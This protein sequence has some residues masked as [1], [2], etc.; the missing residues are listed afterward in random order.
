MSISLIFISKDIIELIDV[1]KTKPKRKQDFGTDVLVV[2]GRDR[3]LCNE[4]YKQ[5]LSKTED[6]F[7]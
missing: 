4:N 7:F 1:G 2:C 6:F 5:E 3:V